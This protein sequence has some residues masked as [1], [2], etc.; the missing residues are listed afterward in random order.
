MFD[1]KGKTVFR[2]REF[3]KDSIPT[4]VAA[5]S[6]MNLRLVPFVYNDESGW[7]AQ[8]KPTPDAKGNSGGQFLL[9]GMAP[10]ISEGC[11]KFEFAR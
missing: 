7:W 2:P 11:L 3:A 9:E 5:L 6:Q 8:P 10:W 1:I 4:L